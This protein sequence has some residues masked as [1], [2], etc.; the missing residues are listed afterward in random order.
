MLDSSG[1]DRVADRLREE[2]FYRRDHRLVF[3]AIASLIDAN[4]PCDVVTVSEW[5]D[6]H[7]DSES[8]VEGGLAYVGELAESTPSA[9]NVA[10]YAE[11]VRERALLREMITAGS[12]IADRA[13]RTEGRA[14]AELLEEAEQRVYAIGDR[15]RAGSGPEA[16]REVLVG[17]MERIDELHGT[18]GEV[19]GVATGFLDLD[20]Y[21]RRAPA[22]RPRRGRGPS[23]DGQDRARAEPGG[24][25]GH[26]R[27]A[28]GGGVQHGDVVPNS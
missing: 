19:T 16:I 18:A 25:R 12:A 5:L 1:W 28:R 8:K 13:F 22:G 24:K 15:R 7:G 6:T 26:R 14:A 11:I 4:D 2:D 21:T 10:A 23:F 9:A 3:R 17:V 27:E 20:R